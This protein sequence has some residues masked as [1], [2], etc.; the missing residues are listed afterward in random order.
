MAGI[1][2]LESILNGT[3]KTE[4]PDSE[5]VMRTVFIPAHLE[6][7]YKKVQTDCDGY[8][9]HTPKCPICGNKLLMSVRPRIQRNVQK[10]ISER[11][12]DRVIKCNDCTKNSSKSLESI[13]ICNIQ[14]KK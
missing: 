5:G 3:T 2:E 7:A 4:M 6:E 13:S 1:S 14:N 8:N 12:Y 10:N 9:S 11:V